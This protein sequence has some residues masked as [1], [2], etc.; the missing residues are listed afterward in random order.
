MKYIVLIAAML[1][2]ACT[3]Y[4][5]DIAAATYTECMKNKTTTFEGYDEPVV[6][7]DN[8]RRCEDAARLASLEH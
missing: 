1:V 8:M 7:F 5:P 6:S 2:T 3:P 4:D